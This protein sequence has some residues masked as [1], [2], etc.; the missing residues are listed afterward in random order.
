ML[1]HGIPFWVKHQSRQ[2]L[3]RL[4]S[5]VWRN[6]IQSVQSSSVTQLCPTHGLQHARLPCPSP[7]PGTC[8]NPSTS[9]HWCHPAI[10]SSA[11]PSPPA[12]NL[13][14]HQ[15][16]VQKSV[17]RIKWPK[18][19]SNQGKALIEETEVPWG[20]RHCT[21]GMPSVSYCSIEFSLLHN[22]M[23]QFLQ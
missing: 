3:S 4:P 5:T 21:S 12:F 1:V 11:V 7:A 18:Y 10:L 2:L 20:R 9:S 17:L 13:S 23:N 15:G 14:K 22:H 8:S 6:L 19:P 16:F